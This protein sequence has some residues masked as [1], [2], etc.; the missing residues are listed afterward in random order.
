MFAARTKITN[1]KV[2]VEELKKSE[3][4]YKEKCEEAKSHCEHVEVLQVE[5]SQQI[6]TKDKDLAGKDV[7][8][9]ELRRRLREAQENLEAEKQKND[10]LEIDLTAEKV[11]AETAEEARKVSQAA[12]KVARKITLRFSRQWS[13]FSLT[14]DGCNIT[15]LGK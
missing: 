3:S 12:L 4:D 6:I 11:K 14:W 7:E 9:A 8:I 5:L 1:L 2:C 15:V 13:P 10:S